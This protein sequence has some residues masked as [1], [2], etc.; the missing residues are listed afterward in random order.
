MR[1]V[2]ENLNLNH[3]LWFL[4]GT[5]V[6]PRQ[7]PIVSLLGESP[8]KQLQNSQYN[9]VHMYMFY[10]M[11]VHVHV[12]MSHVT[13]SKSGWHSVVDSTEVM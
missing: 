2:F 4:L 9:D 13:I 6:I 10:C 12:R 1:A 11:T 5:V 7:D 3:T 8:Y